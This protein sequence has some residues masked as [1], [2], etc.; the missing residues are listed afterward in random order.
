[1]FRMSYISSDEKINKAISVVIGTLFFFYLF[2][3]YSLDNFGGIVLVF[4]VITIILTR[5]DKKSDF[6]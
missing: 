5:N 3:V 6:T 4:G 2:K 1:M